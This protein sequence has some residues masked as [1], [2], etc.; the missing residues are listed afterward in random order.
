[1]EAVKIEEMD[2][3]S[4]LP[5]FILHKILSHLPREESARTSALSK[6]WNSVWNSFPVFEF[7]QNTYME[8]FPG[9][10]FFH[11]V[12]MSLRNFVDQNK[13]RMEKLDVD[14]DMD[15]MDGDSV[16]MIDSWLPLAF[17]N[18]VSE[19]RFEVL[20]G[21][22]PLPQTTFASSESF[23]LLR[24]FKLSH[25]CVSEKIIG[26]ICHNCPH[27]THLHLWYIRGLK[28]L[29]IS[30]LNR[31]ESLTVGIP[32]FY[33][34]IE[35]VSVD[36]ASL[37]RF[38]FVSHAGR[39]PCAIYLTSCSNLKDLCL[40][41]CAITDDLLHSYLSRFP[42]L[43]DLQIFHCH[44]LRRIR[45]PLQRLKRLDLCFRGIEAIQIDAPT[46]STFY[47]T[48]VT[49]LPLFS[50]ENTIPCNMDFTY[51]LFATNGQVDSFSFLKLR[52]FLRVPTRGINFKLYFEDN[53]VRLQIS[54]SL[55]LIL[56]F[57]LAIIAHC[58]D[59][60]FVGG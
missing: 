48:A 29:E 12:D 58:I 40:A 27:I 55:H 60:W 24:T 38:H 26:D 50:L 57:D 53:K 37:K 32:S 30:K 22:Y 54:S 47:Y 10:E 52:E 19:V 16:S 7:D 21:Y 3:I 20:H 1:M 45:I 33:R 43:E 56:L 46:L 34:E 41:N 11:F 44:L 18:G 15:D 9:G 25:V 2:R 51:K 59:Y 14:L 4:E 5:V 42:L 36:A 6:R 23:R 17:R 39:L 13:F 8:R 28:T 49:D 31:L 35:R